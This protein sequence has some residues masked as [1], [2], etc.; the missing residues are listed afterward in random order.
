[1]RECD[2][3]KVLRIM[4]E[5]KGFHGI[6]QC[7]NSACQFPGKK[8]YNK[9]SQRQRNNYSDQQCFDQYLCIAF[10]IVFRDFRNMQPT[11]IQS[12]AV[13][14][15][16]IVFK[17]ELVFPETSVLLN[18]KSRSDYG[19]NHCELQ[20]VPVVSECNWKLRYQKQKSE[21]TGKIHRSQVQYNKHIR[22]HCWICPEEH[23]NTAVYLRFFW[24]QI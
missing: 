7:G 13:I 5:M 18:L 8:D 20:F 22:E 15:D 24:K 12:A 19:K 21:D 11:V 9:N 16:V 2:D 6:G 17:E 3:G 1:M 10:D 4:S 23:E 14:V